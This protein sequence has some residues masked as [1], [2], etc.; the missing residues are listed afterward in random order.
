VPLTSVVRAGCSERV[1]EEFLS[2]QR[3]DER[4]HEG[5]ELGGCGV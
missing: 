3:V 1:G 5:H 2:V 4:D